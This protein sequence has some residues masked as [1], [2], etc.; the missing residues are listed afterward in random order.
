MWWKERIGYSWAHPNE[1]IISIHCLWAIDI[2]EVALILVISRWS[3]DLIVASTFGVLGQ[4]RGVWF[5][6]VDCLKLW[7]EWWWTVHHDSGGGCEGIGEGW[8]QWGRNGR[9][10]EEGRTLFFLVHWY[11]LMGKDVGIHGW[12]RT[13]GMG[14]WS[15]VGVSVEG[16]VFWLLLLL[17]LLLASTL[18]AL[19][20]FFEPSPYDICCCSNLGSSPLHFAVLILLAWVALEVSFMWCWSHK[21]TAACWILFIVG[22]FWLSSRVLCLHNHLHDHVHGRWKLGK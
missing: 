11:R 5:Q 14:D 20:L 10:Q 2:D 18:T 7:D 12:L 16:R 1:S 22:F 4:R 8:G 21:R 19:S 17:L 6:L 15:N 9:W 3:H 13:G